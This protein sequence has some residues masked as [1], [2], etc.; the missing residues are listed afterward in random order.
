[1]TL[2]EIK[3]SMKTLNED[4]DAII[5]APNFDE[6]KWEDYTSKLIKKVMED[7]SVKKILLEGIPEVRKEY[8]EAI[9]IG[10]ERGLQILREQAK[11]LH[12]SGMVDKENSFNNVA[13]QTE[14]VADTI[15]KFEAV[16]NNNKEFVYT[17]KERIADLE[18]K[19]YYIDSTIK[20]RSEFERLEKEIPIE[21]GKT[22]YDES[23][24]SS[25]DIQKEF[26]NFEKKLK[27]INEL[28]NSENKFMELLAEMS[29]IS[30]NSTPSNPMLDMTNEEQKAKVEQ[31]VKLAGLID[32][33]DFLDNREPNKLRLSNPK[34]V[35]KN[36][37]IINPNE[38]VEAWIGSLNTKL[39]DEAKN[40]KI[41][42]DPD[43]LN[44]REKIIKEEFLEKYKNSLVSKELTPEMHKKVLEE[45][46]FDLETLKNSI[47]DLSE[48]LKKYKFLS[49]KNPEE[50]LNYKKEAEK[51]L[52]Y[53]KTVA[54]GSKNVTINGKLK[55]LEIDMTDVDK[56][57]DAVDEIL[58]LDND[59][60]FKQEIENKALILAGD[61]PIDRWYHK[62]ARFIT[63]G[64]YK[65]PE[66]KYEIKLYRK[67]AD[68][69]GEIMKENKKKMDE[70]TQ[71][72]EYDKN[73]YK[74]AAR[75][76]IYGD[77]NI[78]P[79]KKKFNKKQVLKAR[80]NSQPLTR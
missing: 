29:E 27:M 3:M 15:E 34:Y 57:Y 63:F 54:N 78:E 5:I 37:N 51:L 64:R 52:G 43:F 56:R 25:Q 16:E 21:E 32:Q 38:A 65:T 17:D 48:R 42:L 14:L 7:D 35:D 68:V 9:R 13:F 18:E 4:L 80:E 73:A 2:E 23:V 67:R 26:S 69:V 40:K 19:I 72:V 30:F 39:E 75:K 60:E 24:K 58:K 33:V 61:R 70:A 8:L 47:V 1:M 59:D 66:Q 76:K 62:F 44:Q 55:Q 12:D 74:A 31:M 6:T 41:N 28:R 36:G 11:I 45:K 10:V 50:L 49:K 77:R 20:L 71:N 22:I 53:Y 46:D 79:E